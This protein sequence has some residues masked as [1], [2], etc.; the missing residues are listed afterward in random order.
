M[1]ALIQRSPSSP[2][3]KT[4]FVHYIGVSNAQTTANQSSSFYGGHVRPLRS[5]FHMVFFETTEFLSCE[6]GQNSCEVHKKGMCAL[7]T[8]QNAADLL[9]N[10]WVLQV[11]DAK[12]A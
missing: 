1:L 12:N 8:S 9:Q 6:T 3:Y 4:D 2:H 5:D 7:H 10:L 11:I